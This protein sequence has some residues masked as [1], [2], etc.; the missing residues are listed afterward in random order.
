M[1]T[2]AQRANGCGQCNDGWICEDHPDRPMGHDHCGGAGMP[3]QNPSCPFSVKRTG[4]VCPKC[5][6]SQGE[7]TME[8]HRVIRFRCRACSY[9]WYAEHGNVER[10]RK[11]H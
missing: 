6:R 9:E 3:Y 8:T 10:D 7:I 11:T 1:M 4:L 5:R 2:M